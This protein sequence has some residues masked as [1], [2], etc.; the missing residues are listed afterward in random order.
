MSSWFN[1]AAIA[2]GGAT[3]AVCRYG[4]T[5]AAAALPGGSS[6]LG[7]TAVN[8]LGCCLLGGLTALGDFESNFAARCVLA[9]RVGFLGSLT[10][11]ST[12]SAE[13]AAMASA[14]KW[15]TSTAYVLANFLLGWLALTLAA[16]LVKGWVDS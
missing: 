8:V 14:G 12:F 5:L 6:A 13:S 16:A 2:V 11:F 15:G 10:T 3:G 1:L 9:I 7:T 4:V